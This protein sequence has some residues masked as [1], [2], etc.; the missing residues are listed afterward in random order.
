MPF[1]LLGLEDVPSHG[2]GSGSSRRR[3]SSSS[4]CGSG[5]SSSWSPPDT[6]TPMHNAPLN[7]KANLQPGRLPSLA[8]DQGIFSFSVPIVKRQR[9]TKRVV[10]GSLFRNYRVSTLDDYEDEDTELDEDDLEVG[11]VLSDVESN[12]NPPTNSENGGTNGTVEA[13][14]DEVDMFLVSNV[15][16]SPMTIG[17][18]DRKG[19]K[20]SR[21]YEYDYDDFMQEGDEDQDGDDEMETE[22]LLSVKQRGKRAMK[23]SRQSPT[24]IYPKEKSSALGS[25]Y[26][27][28]GNIC[29]KMGGLHASSTVFAMNVDLPLPSTNPPLRE[30]CP[31]L[32]AY[33]LASEKAGAGAGLSRRSRDVR[34]RLGRKRGHT[35]TKKCFQRL[36]A[37]EDPLVNLPAFQN[38]KP[39][40]FRTKSSRVVSSASSSA[41]DI[42]EEEQDEEDQLLVDQEMKSLSDIEHTAGGISSDIDM[43]SVSS[44]ST[45]KSF[46]RSSPGMNKIRK[47]Y[48]PNSPLAKSQLSHNPLSV[49]KDIQRRSRL[50]GFVERLPGQNSTSHLH[51]SSPSSLLP[52]RRYMTRSHRPQIITHKYRV[53]PGKI[54]FGACLP[55]QTFISILRARLSAQVTRRLKIASY[56]ARTKDGAWREMVGNWWGH[57]E[58]SGWTDKWWLPE[59]V[60]VEALL[61]PEVPAEDEIMLSPPSSPRMVNPSRKRIVEEASDDLT[62]GEEVEE[63]WARRNQLRRDEL[64]P[65]VLQQRV[66]A[67]AK[68]AEQRRA[69]A[70][71]IRRRLEE[72]AEQRRME[73]IQRRETIRMEEEQRHRCEEERLQR[74]QERE[75]QARLEFERE[76]EIARL[77]LQQEQEQQR[78]VVEVPSSPARS[79]TSTVLSD[80][81]EYEFP[82]YPIA[83]SRSSH[84]NTDR[85]VPRVRRVISA[86]SDILPDY[87]PDRWNNRSPPP[88]PPYNA[89]TDCQTLIAPIFIDDSDSDGE[90][91]EDEELG[92]ISPMV[93][94]VRETSPE[95][96]VIGSFPSR[97]LFAPTPIHAT[98]RQVDPFRAFVSAL[99]LEEGME[100]ANDVEGHLD[101]HTQENMDEDEEEDVVPGGTVASVFQRVFGMVWGSSAS[102]R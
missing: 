26:S 98:A 8:K 65:Y 80:P 21:E 100:E 49:T 70:E 54:E 53:K 71:V 58:V 55:G 78:V 39:T 86:Q 22:G 46:K 89:R 91:R 48:E 31:D 64:K 61:L 77:S 93:R 30:K 101:A 81:P 33:Q 42:S 69:R 67:E 18:S 59:E 9:Q 88:P 79:E 15:P 75:E 52:A 47:T 51:R 41:M 4:S 10:S 44:G 84:I 82:T 27:V 25:N 20:R 37:S 76:N 17:W 85:P 29:D 57:K 90:D 50:R 97:Q 24:S 99:D 13:E 56:N 74:E 2:S 96:R 87:V 1:N 102:R 83:L 95:L 36:T 60:E 63:R 94:N 38:W 23:Y 5:S 14:G 3:S 11:T 43:K 73:E 66:R 35:Q 68:R 92:M 40:S 7:G 72:I 62:I 32:L 28:V 45:L 34:R 6:P 12:L 16:S 19:K